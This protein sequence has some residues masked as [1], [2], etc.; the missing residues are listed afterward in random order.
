LSDTP[1]PPRR[2]RFSGRETLAVVSGIVALAAT[3][4]ALLPQLTPGLAPCLTSRRQ[5]LTATVI[6]GRTAG[7]VYGEEHTLPQ[8]KEW[9]KNPPPES[10]WPG[11]EV[12]YTLETE[13]LRHHNLRLAWSVVS[14]REDGTVQTIAESPTLYDH[15]DYRNS[16]GATP[17]SGCSS[18]QGGNFFV[19]VKKPNRQYRILLELFDGSISAVNRIAL[20]ESETF[21]IAKQKSSQ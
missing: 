21:Y 14:V 19:P 9:N 16:L 18:T 4:M 13:G 15:L 11:A 17:P 5:T 7:E 12:S 8:L 2:W 10:E 20:F 1:R 3:V 6:P